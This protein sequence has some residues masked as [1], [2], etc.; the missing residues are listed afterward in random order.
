MIDV[1]KSPSQLT[2]TQAIKVYRERDNTFIKGF[3][4][5]Q[6]QRLNCILISQW[7]LTG[8]TSIHKGDV[9]IYSANYIP[10][11]LLSITSK[12]LESVVN[13]TLFALAF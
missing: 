4:P 7:K 12:I 1:N 11:S 3:L 6:T 2:L 8:V 13:D 9:E 10:I 5:K